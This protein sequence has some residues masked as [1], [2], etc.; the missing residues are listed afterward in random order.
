MFLMQ[1]ERDVHFYTEVKGQPQSS[2]SLMAVY[3]FRGPIVWPLALR[4]L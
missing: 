1:E 2:H 3:H 4:A